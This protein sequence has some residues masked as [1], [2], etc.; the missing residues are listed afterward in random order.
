M[1]R[2]WEPLAHCPPRA[3]LTRA[4]GET[5]E[6]S[7][8]WRTIWTGT[9]PY[10]RR[11]VGPYRLVWL[12]AASLLGGE[13][14]PMPPQWRWRATETTNVVAAASHRPPCL[15]RPPGGL[16]LFEV[17]VCF[18]SKRKPKETKK[19]KKSSLKEKKKRACLHA[20][21]WDRSQVPIVPDEDPARRPIIFAHANLQPICSMIMFIAEQWLL[22][23]SKRNRRANTTRAAPPFSR[24]QNACRCP[25][26]S[27]SCS[28]NCSPA[29]SAIRTG[30]CSTQPDVPEAATRMAVAEQRHAQ[31]RRIA[32]RQIRTAAHR[33]NGCNRRH[34]KRRRSVTAADFRRSRHRFCRRCRFRRRRCRFRRSRAVAAVAEPTPRP[35]VRR[36]RRR[37][38]RRGRRRSGMPYE[39]RRDVD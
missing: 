37:R 26:C 29:S 28:C 22:A 10:R 24:L 11:R 15:A 27:T 34:R 8:L 35:A 13:T 23:C 7:P 1:G 21:S 16:P 5:L 38:N 2:C 14:S 19:Q 18:S 25:T 9:F 39:C 33:C 20:L 36:S 17:L 32:R 6:R 31:S 3:R 12:P 4:S 30:V